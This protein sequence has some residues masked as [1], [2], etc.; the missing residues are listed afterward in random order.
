M[1]AFVTKLN[2]AVQVQLLASCA[3]LMLLLLLMLAVAAAS[4]S[5]LLAAV[6]P[7]SVRRGESHSASR[8]RCSVTGSDRRRP[9]VQHT[10]RSS[11]AQT[12]THVSVG[13]TTPTCTRCVATPLRGYVRSDG[14][15]LDYGRAPSRSD[16]CWRGRR[17]ISA[18]RRDL[19]PTLPHHG[20][21]PPHWRHRRVTCHQRLSSG[22]RRRYPTTA[23][24]SR[25][26]GG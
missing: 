5:F 3:W 2:G 24:S 20:G 7:T 21:H 1:D 6:W 17:S 10:A 25:Q 12:R 18:A 9:V 8:L 19:F 23:K 15:A 11:Y 22:P 26:R 14:R 16:G 13:P 4:V